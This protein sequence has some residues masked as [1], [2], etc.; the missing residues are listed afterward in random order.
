MTQ[1]SITRK[2]LPILLLRILTKA[3]EYAEKLKERYTRLGQE[4]SDEIANGMANVPTLEDALKLAQV[5]EDI[6]SFS[7]D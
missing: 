1:H 7:K 5:R 6:K 3:K 2:R 4:I